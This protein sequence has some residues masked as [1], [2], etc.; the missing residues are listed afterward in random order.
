MNSGAQGSMLAKRKRQ[1]PQVSDLHIILAPN[2]D[3]YLDN[4]ANMAC[5]VTES[6]IGSGVINGSS[7]IGEHLDLQHLLIVD[8]AASQVS[9]ACS[10]YISISCPSVHLIRLRNTCA[11]SCKKNNHFATF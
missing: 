9:L 6:A 7:A 2:N 8:Q 3:C 5:D 1:A 4:A 10:T 11:H